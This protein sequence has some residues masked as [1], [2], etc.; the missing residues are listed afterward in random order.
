MLTWFHLEALAHLQAKQVG[1]DGPKRTT[2]P[3]LLGLC[4]FTWTT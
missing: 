4:A 2:M 1:L 3:L